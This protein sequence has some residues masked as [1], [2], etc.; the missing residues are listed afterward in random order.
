MPRAP[1]AGE[2]ARCAYDALAPAY[3]DFTAGYAHERWLLALEALAIEHG[4]SGRRVLD[5]AC[6]TGKSFLPLLERRYEVTGCDLS[7]AMLEQAAAKAPGARLVPADMRA[8]PALGEFD[9]VTCLDDALNY[10][11]SEDDLLE[12][13]RGVR[14]CLAPAGLAVWDVNTQ[15]MYRDAFSRTWAVEEEAR[16][17]LWRGGASERFAAGGRAHA[18]IDL[19]EPGPAGWRRSTSR[20]EQRHWPAET[21]AEAARAAGLAVLAVRGQRSGAR[22]ERGLDEDRHPKAVFLACRDDRPG[23]EVPPMCIGRP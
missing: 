7:E 11:G 21:V 17:M 15:A 4:L 5:V 14:R 9:L 16:L 20:H 12:T 8:L 2:A 18:V 10:L 23:K 6:G 13:L 19:F 1:D 3:D 22:L